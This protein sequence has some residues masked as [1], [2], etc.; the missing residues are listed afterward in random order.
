M[1]RMNCCKWFIAGSNKPLNTP[2]N[3]LL[4]SNWF[5]TN[6]V[7]KN[8]FAALTQ[9]YLQ[10]YCKHGT[11]FMSAPSPHTPELFTCLLSD[12]SKVLMCLPYRIVLQV[13]LSQPKLYMVTVQTHDET[14]THNSS[15]IGWWFRKLRHDNWTSFFASAHC[16]DC[17]ST[18]WF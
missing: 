11:D 2:E 3:C 5:E 12:I 13:L 7:G 6:W 15:R 16:I 18:I 10:H 17:E 9:K 14:A 1:F 4:L 8:T